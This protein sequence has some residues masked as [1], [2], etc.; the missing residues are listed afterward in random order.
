M[1]RGLRPPRDPEGSRGRKG[2]AHL[3]WTR[4]RRADTG[5]GGSND[6]GGMFGLE[7]HAPALVSLDS[8]SIVSD[9]LGRGLVR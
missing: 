6:Q 3:L 2:A 9:K 8:T 5:E 7:S 4:E 1:Q